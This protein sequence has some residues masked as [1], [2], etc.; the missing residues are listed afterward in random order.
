MNIGENVMIILYSIYYE[1]NNFMSYTCVTTNGEL[2][3]QGFI[4]LINKKNCNNRTGLPI[5]IL[6][7]MH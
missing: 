6:I 4:L 7:F 3:K 1:I 2:L 5:R